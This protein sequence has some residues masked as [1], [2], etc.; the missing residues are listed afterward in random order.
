LRVSPVGVAHAPSPNVRSGLPG[1]RSLE[2]ACA[3]PSGA[4]LVTH[5]GSRDT[6]NAS[7]ALVQR[8][9]V[10]REHQV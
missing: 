8:K 9:R 7:L 5:A 1:L 6:D 3:S 4:A 2:A 10:V